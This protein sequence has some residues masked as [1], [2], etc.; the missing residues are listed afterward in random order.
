MTVLIKARF[1]S[2]CAE[3]GEWIYEDELIAA[4][5][6]GFGGTEWVC[7]NCGEES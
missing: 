5:D 2:K 4:V 1:A 6:D 7:E 3:C